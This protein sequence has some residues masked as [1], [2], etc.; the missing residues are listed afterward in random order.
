MT[1]L[2]P[3][4]RQY[5][6]IKEKNKDAILLFRLGD[7]Y[8]MF[9][10]DAKVASRILQITLTSRKTGKGGRVPMCGVP[11]HAIDNYIARLVRAGHR[12]AI[13]EQVEDPAL[14][15][16]IVKRE[17]VRLITPGTVLTDTLL[18]EKKNNFLVA[19]NKDKDKLGLSLV[20]LSTGEFKLTQ[21]KEREELHS[22]LTRLS[23]SECLLPERLREDGS[24]MRNLGE[25]AQM[26]ITYREDF[27]FLPETAY[28]TLTAHFHTHSLKGFG[29]ED[30]PLAIGAAGAIVDYLKETQKTAL[31]HIAK[32]SVYSP[33]EFMVLDGAT[34]RNLELIH[35]LAGAKGASLLAILDETVTSMGGRKMRNWM[36]QPLLKAA[37]IKER[38]EA[39]EEFF[40]QSSCRNKVSRILKGFPDLERLSS[41]ASCGLANARDLVALGNALRIIPEIKK[42]IAPCQSKLVKNLNANLETLDELTELISQAIVDE[43]PLTLREGRLIKEG[44]SEGLDELRKISREGSRW[45]AN[46]QAKEI[47][48]TRVNS[49]K[50]RYNKVFGYYIEV[51]KPNLKLV[52]PDYIRKQTLVNAERFITPELK[53]YESR[54]LGAEERMKDLEYKIFVEVREKVA[55]QS[56][57]I[58]TVADILATLD[59]LTGLAEV[60]VR[61]NYVRPEVNENYLISIKD[62]RHPVLE[63]VL[64]DPFVPNDTLLGGEEN[65]LLIITGPNMAGKSTYIRQ[66]ALIVLMAQMGSFLPVKEATIGVVDR[67]FTRVGALDEL[68]RGMSTFMVEMTETA[69]ILNNATSKS[70][71]VLD[72]IGRGTSTFDGISIAWAVAEYIHDKENLRAKT[73]FATHYHE[74][75]ELSLTL[76]RVK[77]YNVAVREWNEEVIFLRKV[78]EGGSDR[79]YGIHVAKLAGLPREIIERAKDILAKLEKRAFTEDIRPKLS[80]SGKGEMVQLGL[81]DND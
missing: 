36:L 56:E 43:P 77:N 60:A 74:L 81:F 46:L 59:V 63:K 76:P 44:Y 26:L 62:G 75:T 21:L 67:I 40:N 71:I 14:A 16:G 68:S 80:R 4:M 42:E 61:N 78:V 58:Q 13:C 53:D 72:E 24:F 22:E 9:F 29:C 70:L 12:V 6:K 30:L 5:L 37:K 69:N 64:D 15:K 45:I 18:E 52:P 55:K 39:V 20:D 1:E 7:F 34:Q 3:M 49:L 73:L 10:E 50:V 32:L 25:E 51:T 17:T 8:E 31:S 23:P 27:S 38:Q 79:S 48:R 28:Q 2:T 54:I 11:Y 33:S 66:I 47:E 57:R 65:Q 41:R 35:T 19:L